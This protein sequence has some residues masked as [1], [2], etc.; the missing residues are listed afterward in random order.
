M[1]VGYKYYSLLNFFDKATLIYTIFTLIFILFFSSQLENIFPHIVFRLIVVCIAFSLAFLYNKFPNFLLGILR[2]FYPV[3]LLSYWYGETAY[4]NTPLF[5][6]FDPLISKLDQSIFGFQPSMEFS[7]AFPQAWFSELMHF[8][9]FSYYFLTILTCLLVYIYNRKYFEYTVFMVTASFF[10]YYTVFIL[11][12]VAG[13]QFYFPV[14]D[15]KVPSGFLF[16]K[17]V[18]WVQQ[19]GEAPTGAFPS[20]HVGMSIIFLI[21]LFKHFRK[22]FYYTIPLTII[23][24]FATVY[25]KA[26][27]FVDV[28]AGFVSAPLIFL[29]L[30]RYFKSIAKTNSGTFPS[31]MRK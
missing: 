11:F 27:Y 5:E 18:T 21:I 6:K 15:V 29:S 28:I 20:S 22:A 9:Y 23:L 4:L 24:C 12:P 25:I 10:I 19:I 30:D 2:N 1:K 31:K 13:P 17:G 8:G 14:E 7:A 26:H 3:F 16:Q